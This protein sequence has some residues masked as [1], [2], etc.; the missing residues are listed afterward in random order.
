MHHIGRRLRSA[1]SL[2]ATGPQ[3]HY[4]EQGAPGGETILLLPAYADSWFS[5]SR[6]L[7]QLPADDH[8][9]ALDQ[10]GHGDS[11]RPDCCYSVDDFA[12][13][14]VAFLDAAGIQRAILVGHSGSCFTA[15]RVAVTHPDRV[16]GL[17]LIGAPLSLATPGVLRFQA[18]VHALEDPVPAQFVREFQAGAAHVP[19]PEGFMEG[20]VAESLKL[21]ARVWKRALDGLVAFD[22]AA[23]LG[24][25]TTPTLLIWG[26]Q[27]AVV[28]REEQQRLTDAI[29]D[30]RLKVYPQ[31]G[32]SPHWE[33]P[34]AVAAD[35][36][37]FTRPRSRPPHR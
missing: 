10:R 32:H 33:R 31:T 15:R 34:E 13:D 19:L 14:A 20:L 4:T 18:A 22:D 37:T 3:V 27:D 5:Y 23:D 8:A 21:P 7:P 35:L 36:A 1:S 9:Y 28:S 30:A 2:L 26:D 11:E 17:V 25:I 16:A 29:P 24:R 12:A 6:V